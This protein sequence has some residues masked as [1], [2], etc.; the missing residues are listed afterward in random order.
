M[1]I[2]LNLLRILLTL[3]VVMNHFW[4]RPDPGNLRGVDVALW[5]LRT[6][7]VPA[8]MTMTF[9]FTARRFV[10]GDVAWL[11][12]RYV[13]LYEPFVFWAVACFL[14]TMCLS[15][16]D[17]SY[18]A[19]WKDLLWQ[20]ALGHSERLSLTQFWFHTDLLFLTAVFFLA[21][22]LVRSQRA[23][24]YLA[25]A[26]IA[27]GYSVQ[28]AEPAMKAMF[29]WMSFEAKYPVGRVFSMLPY[30]G[31]GILLASV[32][33]RL[34]AAPPGVRLAVAVMGLW[35]VVWVVYAPVAPRPASVVGY[36]GINMSLIAWGMMALFYYIP[37]DRLPAF[38]SKAVLFLSKYCMGVYCIHHLLGKVLFDHVFHFARTETPY[39]LITVAPGWFW[40]LLW[41][42]SYLVCYLVSL[43]PG[44][45]SK[46]IVE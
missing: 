6:L 33:D 4:W 29:G 5:Q 23:N 22:R 38:C 3:G 13:R 45:F 43:I 34:D 31:V 25:L 10:G 16:F 14:I 21:F 41:A 46:R 42:T 37:F 40:L 17:Q 11:K 12:K 2:G 8:F 36:E 18:S 27:I 24:V 30:A 32:K 19:S 1:N 44:S 28:Y 9:F 26:A 15:W 20:L 39:G 7:A 35:L